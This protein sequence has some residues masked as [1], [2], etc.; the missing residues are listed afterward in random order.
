MTHILIISC[1][2][3]FF[4]WTQATAYHYFLSSCGTSFSTSYMA[5]ILSTFVNLGMSLFHSQFLKNSFVGYSIVKWHLFFFLHF[6]LSFHC[7][8][9]SIIFCQVRHYPHCCFSVNDESFFP[10]CFQNL[11][12][13]FPQIYYNISSCVS[14]VLIYLGVYWASWIYR[15][16]VFV[17]FEEVL[18]H[19]FLQISFFPFLFSSS[20]T[21]NTDMLRHIL[22]L[23]HSFP[24]LC[25]LISFLLSVL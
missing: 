3:H 6:N 24:R 21:P 19:Y 25:S 5:D 12:Y 15:L 13:I 2:F 18:G 23:P 17:K 11:L 16:Q 4:W 22:P 1:A 9:D 14:L 10:C 7:L 8:L 20:M